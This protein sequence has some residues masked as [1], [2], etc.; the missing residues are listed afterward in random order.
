M[1]VELV[2]VGTELLLGNITN[3]NAS[4]LAEKCAGLGLSLFYQTVVGD[5]VERLSQTLQTA[6]SRADVVIMTGGLGP[7]TDDLTKETAAQVMGKNLLE[8]SRTVERIRGY[9]I[10][11]SAT[12]PKNN[13]KQALVPEGA[14]ILDNHNGTA[15]GIII[16]DGNKSVILL[17]GP[18]NELIPMFSEQVVPYLK[19]MEPDIIYSKMVKIAGL[20]ESKVAEEIDDLIQSQ[21]NPTIAPYAKTSE[22]HLR[23]TAKAPDEA[24]AN[25]M[26]LPL[27]DE[28]KHRFG[29]W[30]FTTEEEETLE[31]VVVRQL[32]ERKFTI[33]TAESCT[34]GLLTGKLVNVA[35]VSDVLKEGYITYSNEA[36]EKLLSVKHET[37]EMYGA[38]SEQ[39]ACEMAEGG[40]KAADAEVCVAIT[41]IA[42][43]GGGTSEKPVG[44]VYIACCVLDKVSVERYVFKGNREKVRENA[45]M[46]ALDLVRRSVTE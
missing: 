40:C 6:L 44:L 17:P 38:V 26:I 42:G 7:T 25:E 19:K 20:G 3:T 33:T 22:V 39:T 24:K 18:P 36:K 2:S 8:D 10:N 12:I 29:T 15:P 16:E 27:I 4:Y 34:G 13:W 28:I 9:M 14:I 5:N 43:P 46:K 31:D 1:V 45:V 32:K 23:I 21:T 41:G 35:G 37:L 11:R 30:V